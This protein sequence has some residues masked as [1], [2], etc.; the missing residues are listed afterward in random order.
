VITAAD[1]DEISA[2]VQRYAQLVDRREIA[3]AA[4][5]FTD[6]AVLALPDPPARLGPVRP[7][8]GRAEIT[9]ALRSLQ[10]IPVTL[11]AVLGLVI[12]AD[13]AGG[14]VG[15]VTGVAHHVTDRPNGTT[16]DLVWYLHYADTYQHDH[17]RW[18]IASRALQIDWI[19]TRPVRHRRGPA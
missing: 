4:D 2:L 16:A 1:R 9:R 17:G 13:G 10:D 11:H 14:A 7:H 6:E 12:D 3:A 15:S 8:A 5:L 18:L 19:E